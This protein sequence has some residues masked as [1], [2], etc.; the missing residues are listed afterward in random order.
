MDNNAATKTQAMKARA[1]ALGFD[2]C[3]GAPAGDADPKDNLRQWLATGYPAA[4]DALAEQ[5]IQGLPLAS[6][7]KREEDVFLPGRETSL[8]LPRR[9]PSLKLLQRARDEAHRVAVTYSRKR[10]S[11]RTTTS[12]LSNI[13]GA[14]TPREGATEKAKVRQGR[15]QHT[16]LGQHV[17]PIAQRQPIGRAAILDDNGKRGA[18]PAGQRP[19]FEQRRAAARGQRT[20]GR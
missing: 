2:A 13:R 6:L 7:A 16:S 11:A 1:Q 9:A 3:G 4:R 5:G 18:K 8:Q 15:I 12:T 19:V 17:S 20:T 14:G 10:R